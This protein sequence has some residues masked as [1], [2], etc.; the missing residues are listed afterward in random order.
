MTKV[1]D[2]GTTALDDIAL[3][4]PAGTF[5]GLLGP[6][7]AGKTT[8]IGV[9]AGLVRAAPGKVFVFG[10]DV[11]SDLEA[12]LLVGL[13]PQE[14]HLDR[15]LTAHE[16]LAYHGRYF[17]I[18]KLEAS[19][20]ARELLDVFD[21]AAKAGT[22]PNR[23]SGGMRRRLLIARALVHRPRLAILDEPTAGVDL[24]L[25]HDLWR[26]LRRLHSEEG[27]TVLLTTHY[28]EEAEAL[29]ER[30]AFIRGGRIS[31]EGTPAEL[32]GRFGGDGL[33]DAYLEAMRA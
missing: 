6:N 25:R 13:A 2:D 24:E 26:Y 20:R 21:L 7:G 19:E 28:I 14:V 15:F 4:I 17:G 27:L 22:K 33:E 32:T 12:R 11:V 30:I 31:A 9:A 5:F 3:R 18:G 16:V 10:H 29:C 1:Y 8:L 23:L